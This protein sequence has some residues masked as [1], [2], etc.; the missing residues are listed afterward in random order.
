MPLKKFK[1]SCSTIEEQR[2]RLKQ[3]KEEKEKWE[4]VVKELKY[5]T[6]K[7]KRAA[8]QIAQQKD[9]FSPPA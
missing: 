1:Q 9:Q 5:L 2:N 8:A 7:Y 3:L 6:E 4:T